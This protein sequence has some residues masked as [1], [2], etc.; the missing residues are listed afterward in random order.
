MNNMDITNLPTKINDDEAIDLEDSLSSEDKAVI[1]QNTLIKMNVRPVKRG[2]RKRVVLLV[3]A[4]V[5]ILGAVT[6]Y[7]AGAFGWDNRLSELLGINQ[8]NKDLVDG[9]GLMI[10][11]GDTQNG[12]KIE[13]VSAIG[14]KYNVHIIG[15][16]TLPEGADMS[17]SYFLDSV[18]FPINDFGSGGMS[19][20]LLEDEDPTDN[21]I[22]FIVSITRD[23]GVRGKKCSVEIKDI[24]A[25]NDSSSE[26]VYP[27]TW[28]I[29]WKLDYKD[30]SLTYHPKADVTIAGKKVT[31][32]KVSLSPLSVTI[33]ADGGVIN[34]IVDE[35]FSKANDGESPSASLDIQAVI[36]S[37]GTRIENFSGGNASTNPFSS[38]SSVTFAK[39][40]DPEE[41]KS[42]IVNDTEIPLE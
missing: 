38:S 11:Q 37:D 9:S 16:I 15:E 19:V 30:A 41:V 35:L 17:K 22:P 33:K 27:G 21:I 23:K 31:I 39:I 42:I 6:A 12:V 4:A 7:A 28:N 32:N 1:L 29:S 2:L 40:I 20:H 25:F 10:N 3:A 5:L 36:L 24:V 13:M 14:D 34:T 26:V 8:S 18:S